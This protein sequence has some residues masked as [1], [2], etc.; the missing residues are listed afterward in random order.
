MALGN[1]A[2]LSAKRKG[3]RLFAFAL[4]S[5]LRSVTDKAFPR[6]LSRPSRLLAVTQRDIVTGCHIMSRCHV[7][8][9]FR[10]TCRLAIATGRV[11][12]NRADQALLLGAADV[13]P[14]G[15]PARV[16][17]LLLCLAGC[18]VQRTEFAPD[19]GNVYGHNFRAVRPRAHRLAVAAQSV[20]NGRTKHA[21]RL[22]PRTSFGRAARH[23]WVPVDN[24]C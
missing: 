19:E 4:S 10:F 11:L 13:S 16:G 2:P 21:Q 9:V 3:G 24:T 8:L 20:A 6:L 23:R 18:C 7:V 1:P 15:L 14:E 5:R 17:A 22:W 12:L